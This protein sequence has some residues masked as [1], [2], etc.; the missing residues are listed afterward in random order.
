MPRTR[1]VAVTAALALLALPTG[2]RAD[3]GA[4]AST[5][6]L[7]VAAGQPAL[8]AAWKPGS[9]TAPAKTMSTGG[10]P[11]PASAA[12]APQAAHQRLTT[13]SLPAN[14]GLNSS[15]QSYLNAGGVDAVGAYQLLGDR[16]GQL[17]GAGEIVTNVSIGDLTDQ[18]MADAGD[19]Y[20]AAN[21]PTT[22]LENGRRYLDLPAM[23]L[24]PTYV[25]QANGRL[26]P[27]GST[28]GQ[29]PELGEVLL[30]F[31]VMAPLPADRQR[32]GNPG[33]GLTDLLGI[34]PGAQYRLVVPQDPT[35]AGIATAL[36]AA[37]EQQP[38]PNVITA[39]LGYGTDTEGFPGRY[40]EDDPV[41]R[42][43]ITRI[44]HDLGIVVVISSNDG[45][46][47]YTPAAV[48][49][50]GGSTPTDL[51]TSAR[52]QTTIDDD[53]EST[54][55]T[56]VLDSGAIAAGGT[57]LDD[58]LGTAHDAVDG[59]VAETR[60]SGAGDFSSG[61][62]SRVDLSAP[63]D[64]IVVYQHTT[65][66]SATDVTPV[67]EGGTSA[68]APEIAAAAAVVL[69][70]A[71][72][73]GHRINPAGVRDLLKRTGRAVST[74]AQIDRSLQVGPQVDLT[75]AVSS[76][77]PGRQTPALVRVSVAHRVTLAEAGGEFTEYTDPDRI[78]LATGGT[79]E[80]LVGPVTF[81]LD[82]TGLPTGELDYVL[83]V[84]TRE[85]HNDRPSIR[86]LPSDL[87]AAAGLPLVAATDRTV[88]Y[89]L[90]VRQHGRVLLSTDRTIAVGPTDGTYAEAVPPTA[91]AAVAEGRSV[92]VHYD[93]T[94]VRNLS[95]P[96]LVVSEVGHWNAQ[97]A[98]LFTRAHLV[99]LTDPTGTVTLPASAFTGGAGLYGIGIIQRSSTSINTYGEFAPIRI[100][101][102]PLASR[103]AAPTFAGGTH[104]AA[105][106][107]S[108][109]K[110]T[111]TY[112]VPGRS[113]P[114]TL[115][116]S[117]PGPT[118]YGA[119]NTFTNANGSRRDADGLTTGSVVYQR[120]PA[121]HGTVTLDALK[122]G[123]NTSTV[124]NVRVIGGGQ[125]SP[126]S[127]LEVD[128][129]LAPGDDVIDSFGMAGASSVAAVHDDS[130]AALLRYDAR[131]ESWGSA[132][133]RDPDPDGRYDVLGVD[134]AAQRVVVL[135]QSVGS[136]GEDLITYDLGTGRAL[137]RAA[138]GTA[139]TVIGGR[140]DASR[141]RAALLVRRTADNAD[142]VLPVDVRTGTVG[143]PIAT[144]QTKRYQAIDL[145]PATGTVYLAHLGAGPICFSFAAADVA[146]VDLDTRTVTPSGSLSNCAAFFASDGAGK[147]EYQAL[148]RSFS[149]NIVG[150][151]SLQPIGASTL[152]AA[153]NVVAVRQQWP[154]GLTVDG[155]NQV[156]LVPFA[157]PTPEPLFGSPNGVLT[158][159]NST[160]EIQLASLSGGAG[161]VLS[162]FA[163]TAGIAAGFDNETDRGVQ[164]D[165]A[166]RTG[167]T[168][169]PGARQIREFAY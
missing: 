103:P 33:S 48:G 143:A 169:G 104:A 136:E 108:A 165:P 133:V 58:T 119:V 123:L 121:G 138:L 90:Q 116:I 126:S 146:A 51:A 40:L 113:Q 9:V 127:R 78:D 162:G 24:I 37:A 109:P 118:V 31:G 66:G 29:D 99:D 139:Y 166:T 8:G 159:S 160:A 151:L 97:L 52:K 161:R 96:Q 152:A 13:G 124:Y 141:H 150:S 122:L 2:A 18:S 62:G 117:A 22:V 11:L 35:Y 120:L 105:V 100:G 84:G 128:D 145:D 1:L 155:K 68:S 69:Q 34:A 5:P 20:V 50:D 80:G 153:G 43:L 55:P 95:N 41:F 101:T 115:E 73:T 26:D 57:T 112:A 60:I 7:A 98:P 157:T 28:E 6:D 106:T 67:L 149:V 42:Q 163:F 142:L 23:P 156:A 134:V 56:R 16:Y 132:I 54:T 25:A 74:P 135:H 21:G 85:F 86:L 131:T 107:R 89:T 19:A 75:A 70:T 114:A 10:V 63:S 45:T 110:F 137:G 87:L 46:R 154:L 4:T 79:G 111:L 147:T 39:S 53:Q 36:E 82:A 93:L 158:D 61:F 76:L 168:F 49:P 65:G 125:A 144:G 47:L 92:T 81:G 167:W 44:T 102:D 38:R 148:F 30:D 59:T 91:P 94:G 71:R 140:V 12:P 32:P 83:R 27:A 129:R 164:I 15:L 17:P 14:Y 77:L 88:A 3:S 130:G 72:L 64:N